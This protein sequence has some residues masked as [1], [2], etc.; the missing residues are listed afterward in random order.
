MNMGIWSGLRGPDGGRMGEN[1]SRPPILAPSQ[2]AAWLFNVPPVVAFT[3]AVLAF[4]F[5]ASVIAP[6]AVLWF[7]G[8]APGFSPLRFFA[9]PPASGGV[10]LWASPLV[11][12]MLMHANVAHL[13]FNSLW[14]IVFGAPLARR[15]RSPARFLAFFALCGAAG[16]LFYGLFH[17][18]DTAILIGASG[19]VTGLLGGLV[20]FA[21]QNPPWGV[22]PLHRVPLNDRSVIA[23]SS[24]VIVINASVAFVG[25]GFG[26]A[27]AD[28]AWEAHIG[29]Y[30]FGLVAFP[31][32]DRRP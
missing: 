32:F 16:A 23:W 11:S 13:L 8:G 5:I 31:L 9:G 21:F 27:G 10:I 29:G 1:D 30:L 20:R 7:A 19:G 26:A 4:F 15:L 24:A 22:P 12:H 3:T 28:V 2:R 25:A 14:L 17:L 6:R 18:R